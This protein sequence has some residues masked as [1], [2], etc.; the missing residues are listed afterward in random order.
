MIEAGDHQSERAT[1]AALAAAGLTLVV[2]VV[3]A[4][5]VFDHSPMLLAA[6]AFAAAAGALA[7][8]SR[9]ALS[10]RSLL[11]AVILVILFI[12]IRRYELPGSLPFQLEPYRVLIAFVGLGLDLVAPHRPEGALP[13]QPSARTALRGRARLCGVVRLQRRA[14]PVAQRLSG[15]DEAVHVPAQLHAR[16]LPDRERRPDLGRHRHAAQ[17]SRRRGHGRGAPS[18]SSSSTPGSTSSTTWT[19]SS[20]SSSRLA[21]R[22]A[23]SSGTAAC[24]ST[25]RR[26]TRS[27][28]ASCSCC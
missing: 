10:W 23:T 27:A 9:T 28:S 19:V 20:R 3:A 6:G 13:E 14:D 15:R 17:G 12:P 11:S 8:T 16:L 25:P 4:G 5:V 1:A 7:C 22:P 21:A 18:P 2:A 26:S 24:A